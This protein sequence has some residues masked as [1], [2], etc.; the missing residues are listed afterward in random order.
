MI[1]FRNVEKGTW[2]CEQS[3][4]GSS[5][6]TTW[7]PIHSAVYLRDVSFGVVT[8]PFKVET[9]FRRKPFSPLNFAHQGKGADYG[10]AIKG[11]PI[12]LMDWQKLYAEENPVPTTIRKLWS[13]YGERFY[14]A[15]PSMV[16]HFKDKGL[17]NLATQSPSYTGTNAVA[18]N[19]TFP[20]LVSHDMHLAFIPSP[21]KAMHIPSA[22]GTHFQVLF[23]SKQTVR[24]WSDWHTG[25][26]PAWKQVVLSRAAA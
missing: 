17:W 18:S 1:I 10:I 22:T 6:L 12:N 16:K 20:T 21:V 11:T 23:D 8:H 4:N 2:E 3:R 19:R 25:I 9:S 13:R 24:T 14:S 26:E 15:Y 7:K 5:H